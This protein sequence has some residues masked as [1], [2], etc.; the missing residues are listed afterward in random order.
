MGQF[1]INGAMVDSKFF[2]K[3]QKDD[4]K[5]V[6]RVAKA[7]R[8]YLSAQA[9]WSRF[10]MEFIA[11]VFRARSSEEEWDKTMTG[12]GV[13]VNNIPKNC[14][15]IIKQNA[16]M[17]MNE[18]ARQAKAII[19]NLLTKAAEKMPA[20]ITDLFELLKT[21]FVEKKRLVYTPG[22]AAFVGMKNIR[23]QEL[24]KAQE[25]LR[26][27]MDAEMGRVYCYVERKDED[28]KWAVER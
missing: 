3:D 16:Y 20:D 14:R 24:L 1:E 7:Y 6:D 17:K 25:L 18:Y 4:H 11:P 26:K 15:V 23:N 2:T 12:R 22:I 19:D 8:K 5:L 13:T 27:A 21:M 10:L 28:G 9:N